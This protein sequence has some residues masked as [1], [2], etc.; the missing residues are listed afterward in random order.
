MTGNTPLCL[1]YQMVI[2]YGRNYLKTRT[3]DSQNNFPRENTVEVKKIKQNNVVHA[4]S[5]AI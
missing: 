2:L 5:K 3:S 1:V 4:S